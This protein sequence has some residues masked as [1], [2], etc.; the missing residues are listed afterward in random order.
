MICS[1]VADLDKSLVPIP[2]HRGLVDLCW[3]P[4]VV[5]WRHQSVRRPSS[6]DESSS[7]RERVSCIQLDSL[8]INKSPLR[9]SP[10]L[11]GLGGRE[12]RLHHVSPRVSHGI[13]TQSLL[14]V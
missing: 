8:P 1:N 4:G 3:S 5:D 13:H 6:Q 2:T 7:F 9:F 14:C 10:S 12:L 11:R